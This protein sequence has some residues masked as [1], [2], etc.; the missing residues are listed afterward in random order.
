MNSICKISATWEKTFT[1][2]KCTLFLC[3]LF[4]SFSAYP[5]D[6]TLF[7]KHWLVQSG[8]TLP[9]RILFPKNYDSSKSYPV[10]FFLHGR[11]EAGN[12]NEKQLVHGSAMFLRDSIRS[13]FPAIVIFPQCGA[14]DYWSNVI[15]ASS[16]TVN[17]KRMFHFIEGGEPSTS[18]KLLITLVEHIL[19]RYPIN[20][21]QVYVGGLSM[22]GMG[23]YELVRLMPKTFAAAFPIC[24]GAH[25]GTGRQIRKTSWWLFHGL[26]DDVVLPV[27][28]QQM[29]ASLKKQKADVRATYYP[30]A[31]HNSWDAAFA[32]PL[33]MQ[34]MFS[35]KKK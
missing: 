22:G 5:Q 25:S 20:K 30:N 13:Q 33:L 7:Q 34:W 14:N 1:I 24:G 29:E 19:M 3:W 8:D 15:Q 11:G 26:K 21:Q 17:A 2:I 4:L 12:D 10:V 9:Y 31:N 18:M 6:K 28:T 16:G 32:E 23:T 27:F 35:K